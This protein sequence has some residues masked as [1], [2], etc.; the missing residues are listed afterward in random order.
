MKSEQLLIFHFV[1]FFPEFAQNSSKML[2]YAIFFHMKCEYTDSIRN[3]PKY[4]VLF[5]GENL[6]HFT[7]ICITKEKC[8]SFTR[9]REKKFS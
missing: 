8:L 2:V 4:Q 7:K 3:E 5:S 1:G 6:H 9:T